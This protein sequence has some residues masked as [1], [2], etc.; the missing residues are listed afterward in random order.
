MRNNNIL[1]VM[2]VPGIQILLLRNLGFLI[3]RRGIEVKRRITQ[4]E[5][6]CVIVPDIKAVSNHIDGISKK[7]QLKN[8]PK[9]KAENISANS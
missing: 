4:G 5:M 9:A 6:D 1:A 3:E 7:T 2:K 8:L